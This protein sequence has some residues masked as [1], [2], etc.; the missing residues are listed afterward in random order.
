[1]PRRLIGRGSDCEILIRS[2]TCVGTLMMGRS[3]PKLPNTVI[4]Y[5]GAGYGTRAYYQGRIIH[6]ILIRY[7]TLYAT[8]GSKKG[9]LYGE[10]FSVFIFLPVGCSL[11]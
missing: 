9:T 5:G 6:V 3:S 10:V 8:E 7:Y 11:P 1:M 4:L 2:G